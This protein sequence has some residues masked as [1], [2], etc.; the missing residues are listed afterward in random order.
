MK[1]KF[2]VLI[3]TFVGLSFVHAQQKQN[4]IVPN[5]NL[6]TENIAAI[7]SELASQVKKYSESRGATLAEI[8]PTRNDIIINTRFGSTSQLHLVSQPMGARKQIT[9]F[10]EPV[11]GAT[12][13]PTKGEYLI[14]SKDIGGNEFGQLFKLDLKT[15]QSTLLTDGG[16]SQNGGVTWRE[17]GKG[18]YYSS[19]KRN[20]GDRD[21]Y[22][23]DPNNPS[24]NKL[25]LEVK[26]GGWGIH[27]ISKDNKQLLVGEGISANESHLWSLDLETG[28]LTEI[29]DRKSKSI[30]QT[31]AEYSNTADEIWYVTDR[32]NEFE[33][34][35]TL[36]LKTKKTTYH[37]SKIPWNVERYSLS[38]DKK[39]IVFITNEAGINKMYLMN[40]GDKSYSEV[41][42]I[43]IGLIAGADFT[44]DNQSIFFVQSTAQSAADVYK[45][46]LK[47]EKIEQWTSSELGEMQQSDMSTPKFIEWKSFDNLMI[48]G[49]YYPA[50]PK[51]TGKRP[52]LINIHGGPE[53][54]SQ[55]SFLGSN[56]YYTNEMGVSL[57]F[58]NVRGSSGFGK[59]FLAK[60]NGFLREDSVKDIGALLDWIAL[61]PDLDKDKIMIMG[62]SYGG[63][64]SLATAYHYADK[65]K[66]SVDVVG[67][68]NFNT[69]L[70]NTEEYR[71]D[72]R[73]VEY[74]DEREEKMAA[75]FEKMA[76]LNNTDKIK[77]PMFIIQGK[78]DPRVPVTEAIQMRDKLKA[79]G[80]T[81]WYLEAK[82]E[83]H[84]FKKKANIDYQR[85]A[86][87]RF[88]QEYLLK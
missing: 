37:T 38:E 58:P 80:N 19:T 8:H 17:D 39:T 20:G 75:F 79:Q 21:I 1:I 49:F 6:I 68:S 50:S 22:Y 16:K 78:N 63:Y 86:V 24:S 84:G 62:G 4:Y 47:S 70:K 54:Q 55:A 87:I 85:L 43:P 64:M 77:K 23:M 53:G 42:N 31:N 73:R 52:V 27:D 56:N 12:Y 60:D 11:S 34:L 29:T 13:E 33:R 83:G 57:I 41:K 88:M 46:N 74:G 81:V 9:F 61:Q 65:L 2:F 72:L 18:F 5:E 7:P 14:Y 59:T 45:L 40:T 32:D 30:V 15:L 67:I 82:D 26:G 76:P 44:K 10:D 69:F 48:S 35:A 66:C 3:P 36:N 71:R 51:F 28:K 25:I